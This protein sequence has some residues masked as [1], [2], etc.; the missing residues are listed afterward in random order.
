MKVSFQT[1]ACP[2]WS[3]EHILQQATELGYDGIELR[4]V[5]G[6]MYLPRVNEFLPEN[7]EQ[8]CKEL[9]ERGLSISCMDTSCSFHDPD[10]FESALQEGRET[11]DL[12]QAMGTSYIRVFGDKIPD[13]DRQD[14]T[15][16]AI[17]SGLEELGKYAESRGVTVLL[18]TH[19]DFWSSD[20]L[21]K[22]LSQTKSTAVGILWDFEHPY[23][24]GETAAYTFEKLG[25]WI[26]HTHIKDS[27]P[28]AD[29]R[30]LCLIGEGDV[31]VEEMV[32]LLRR[33]GY[34]GWFSLEYEK[35]WVPVLE[36]PEVSL[37]AFKRYI[38]QILK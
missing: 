25:K 24:H 8:T 21:L 9:A 27:K 1:L 10:R 19:G 11:I 5:Q 32:E 34:D 28:T 3:W 14:Q 4:G 13:S 33:N 2:D 22:V 37:P 26:K 16:A 30:K 38:D 17:A 7:I 36:E 12:A 6:E 15:L 23:I 29:G 35:K 31:P 18:E 20:L